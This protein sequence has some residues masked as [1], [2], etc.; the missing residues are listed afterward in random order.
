MSRNRFHVS[1]H[2]KGWKVKREGAMRS[3]SLHQTKSAAV[4]AARA[5]ARKN[6]PSQLL[7]HGRSGRY[8][9]ESTYGQD[10]YPPEG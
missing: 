9:S 10:P 3:S 4:R 6:R 7:V 5:I 8:Q 1:K 2:P